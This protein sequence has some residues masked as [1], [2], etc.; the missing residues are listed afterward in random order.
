[1]RLWAVQRTVVSCNAAMGSAKCW[2]RSVGIMASLQAQLQ[3]DAVSYKAAAGVNPWERGL[4]Y[5]RAMTDEGIRADAVAQGIAVNLQARRGRWDCCLALA[6][7]AK[8]ICAAMG[9][10]DEWP[11]ALAL[12]ARGL[13]RGPPDLA[14]WNRAA[15]IAPWRSACRLLEQLAPRRLQADLVSHNSALAALLSER[16]GRW[17]QGLAAVELSV[18]RG[19]RPTQVTWG[20]LLG[21][22]RQMPWEAALQM[23]T[24]CQSQHLRSSI[25]ESN[26][27][28]A[29]SDGSS[30]G[31]ALDLLRAV[32]ISG[33]AKAEAE[34]VAATQALVA[35]GHVQHWQ[36]ALGVARKLLGKADAALLSALVAACAAAARWQQ[37]LQIFASLSSWRLQRSTVAFNTALSACARA[38]QWPSALHLLED[39]GHG[40]VEA[41]GL[42][43]STAMLALEGRA[44]RSATALLRALPRAQVEAALGPVPCGL[45]GAPWPR[46]LWLAA[47]ASAA[48]ALG[49]AARWRRAL[50]VA[51]TADASGS[52]SACAAAGLACAAAVE[53]GAE[54]KP[55]APQ[56]SSQK[57]L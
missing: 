55:G 40:L 33:P 8:G 17:A 19:L 3:V 14:L 49:R 53:K 46:A 48:T 41:D 57:A 5:L 54:G 51:H 25:S 30:W 43:C 9:A 34:V 56:T 26:V 35:Y 15:R 2:Q 6:L 12:F 21:Q 20:S 52:S 45:A 27:L 7:D 4:C 47:G 29:C 32:Q 18:G 11:K 10:G 23:L 39:L 42:T 22:S 36:R 28:A 38:E 44:W 24:Q 50:L 13:W 16:E 37:A 31:A 1:M